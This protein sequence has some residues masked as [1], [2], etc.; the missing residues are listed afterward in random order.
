MVSL[1]AREM[2]ILS[3]VKKSPFFSLI[4]RAMTFF[5][6]YSEGGGGNWCRDSFECR[7]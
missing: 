4:L 1:E 3:D 7:L 2:G 5:K 6:G